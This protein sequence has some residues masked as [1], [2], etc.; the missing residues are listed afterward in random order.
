[1]YAE[2]LNKKFFCFVLFFVFLVFFKLKTYIQNTSQD[3]VNLI[4]RRS[5]KNQQHELY[6][7]NA[8]L[9]IYKHMEKCSPK[10]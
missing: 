8:P 7:Q 4:C 1:M 10:N 5:P 2:Q 3:T 6:Y 9:Q